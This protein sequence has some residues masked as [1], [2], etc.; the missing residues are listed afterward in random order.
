MIPLGFYV[1][2]LMRL[3]PDA[4]NYLLEYFES[5]RTQSGCIMNYELNAKQNSI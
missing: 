2:L 1:D 5:P 4:L 3:W